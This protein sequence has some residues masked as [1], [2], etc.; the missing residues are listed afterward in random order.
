M[1]VCSFN[2]RELGAILKKSKIHS[3]VTSHRLE[4]MAIQET[5][6]EEIDGSLC[7]QL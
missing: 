4:F 1:Q 2:I 6:M 7:Q 5:K 3:L